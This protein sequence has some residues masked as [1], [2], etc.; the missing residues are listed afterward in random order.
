MMVRAL[1]AVDLVANSLA[2]PAG[3]PSRPSLDR[4]SGRTRA[5]RL[6]REQTANSEFATSVRWFRG[7]TSHGLVSPHPR[8]GALSVHGHSTQLRGH[9]AD[10]GAPSGREV[11]QRVTHYIRAGGRFE[12]SCAG[13]MHKGFQLPYVELGGSKTPRIRKQRRRAKRNIPARS[14]RRTHGLSPSRS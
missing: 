9:W 11:G 8:T 14:A 1:R 4:I 6:A 5:D 12:R 13:L 2:L 3:Y 7:A 10:T